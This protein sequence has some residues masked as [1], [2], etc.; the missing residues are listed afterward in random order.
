MHLLK[1]KNNNNNNNKL[2]SIET[3]QQAFLA[4]LPEPSTETG[5]VKLLSEEGLT[6]R[7]GALDKTI[8]ESLKDELQNV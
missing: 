8:T 2:G 5:Q 6:E 7:L 1:K 3:A 4:Q